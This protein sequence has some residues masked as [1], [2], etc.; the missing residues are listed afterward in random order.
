M[1]GFGRRPKPEPAEGIAANGLPRES[2]WDYPRPPE[3]R[4]E[5]RLVTVT[6]DGVEVAR[7]E[8]AVKV[9][10]TAGAP[11]VYIPPADIEMSLLERTHGGSY[12]EWKGAAH[13]YDL[14]L[15]DA[16]IERV[17]W[18]YESPTASFSEI[19]GWPAFYPR[20]VECRLAGELVENQP[21]PFYGGW[22]TAE[23]SGPIKGEPGSEFW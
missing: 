6:A 22:V 17:A 8:R 9:C 2:V 21:G 3:I 20:L 1:P 23:I 13:Y 7:S 4:P 5:P 15:P 11:V 19:T 14:V 10:E 16:R 12:C 18:A